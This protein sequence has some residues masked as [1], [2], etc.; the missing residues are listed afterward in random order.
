FLRATAGPG[1]LE[2]SPAFAASNRNKRSIE[3]DLRDAAGRETLLALIDKADVFIEN[4]AGGVAER[5]GAGYDAVSARNPALVYGSS[6]MLGAWGPASA[7]S[8][9]GPS[10]HAISGLAYLWTHPSNPKPEGTSLVHPDHLAGRVLAMAVI[11][12]LGERRTTGRGQFID[13][14]LAELAMS[15]V[16]ERFIEASLAGQSVRRGHDHPSFVPHGVFPTMLPEEWLAIAVETD[17][18]W[19]ALRKAV[20]PQPWADA[21][22]LATVDGR[23]AA[24]TPIAEGLAAWT[25][26]MP[27]QPAFLALQA[28]GVPAMPVMSP[29]DQLADVH[30]NTRGDFE[31]IHHPVIG[32]GRYDAPPFRFE[33]LPLIPG[34]RARLLGEHSAEIRRE[35]LGDA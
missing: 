2:G 19:A 32:S 35:W 12:A 34:A 30:F 1:N 21:P 6:Q 17:A 25:R 24:R 27:R 18:Q 9:F 22:G 14:S 13:V 11:A 29:L 26:T 15:S 16:A 31:T 33:R 8:G 4:F 20:G 10:N 28:A 7:Y 3:L 23:I 5:F